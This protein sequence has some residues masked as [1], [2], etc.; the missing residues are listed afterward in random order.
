MSD[1]SGSEAGAEAGAEQ[2]ILQEEKD[3]PSPGL[4]VWDNLPDGAFGAG[5]T[6]F[7][8]HPDADYTG[9]SM[10]AGDNTDYQD[11]EGIPDT[12]VEASAP[13]L[14]QHILPSPRHVRFEV[15]TSDHEPSEDSDIDFAGDS[16]NEDFTT[17]PKTLSRE[18]CSQGNQAETR[19]GGSD[20]GGSTS[21]YES[22]SQ[23]QALTLFMILTT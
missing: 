11:W 16:V 3:H 21:G 19:S 7:D 18:R 6:Y 20:D 23:T 17:G 9:S 14:E 8:H 13:M 5:E 12:P 22:G 15:Q 1:S 2:D 4:P 10:L